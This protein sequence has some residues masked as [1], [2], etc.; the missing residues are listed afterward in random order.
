MKSFFR[1]WR[2]FQYIMV[3][4]LLWETGVK[5]VI[6]EMSKNDPML[7]DFR[8]AIDAAWQVL[9]YGRKQ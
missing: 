6:D 2:A 4:M 9:R 8:D 1:R 5:S 3:A 7:A